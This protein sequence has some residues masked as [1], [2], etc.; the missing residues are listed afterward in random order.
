[1]RGAW[2]EIMSQGCQILT[3][4]CELFRGGER[5]NGLQLL[6]GPCDTARRRR[7]Q[8]LPTAPLKFSRLAISQPIF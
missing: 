2:F 4:G 1:M 7:L 6:H 8:H 5:A 3:Q